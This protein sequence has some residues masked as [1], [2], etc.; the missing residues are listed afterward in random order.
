MYE[1]TEDVIFMKPISKQIIIS[2]L[3]SIEKIIKINAIEHYCLDT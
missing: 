1:M 3:I 2:A